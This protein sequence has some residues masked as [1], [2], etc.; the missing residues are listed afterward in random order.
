MKLEKYRV[1]E[2]YMRRHM[3]DSAH[4]TGHIQRVLGMAMLLARK[5]EAVDNDVLIAS[6]LLHDVGRE[7]QFRTGESHAIISA[8]MARAF[9]SEQGEEEA[10]IDH[11]CACI[12]THSFRRNDPPA[13]IAARLLYDADKLD[14]VGAIGMA[15]TFLY[16][17]RVSD[18]IYSVG[19]NGEVLSGEEK[20]PSFY[21]E[22]RH[23]LQNMGGRFLTA[24]AKKRAAYRSE[25]ARAFVD[26]LYAEAAAG[27]S[28]PGWRVLP[29][30][31]TARQRRIY[32]IALLMAGGCGLSAYEELAEAVMRGNAAEAQGQA[33]A[34]I[35]DAERLD[36]EGALGIAQRFIELGSQGKNM[37]LIFE[38]R[39]P[40]EYRTGS[41]EEMAKAR[42]AAAQAYLRDLRA[43]MDDGME[44]GMRLLAGLLL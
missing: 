19:E 12:R 5:E 16:Q 27:E 4:D 22:Y 32:N 24:E 18:P 34:L 2:E 37:N 44:E 25:S 11:V 20:A 43:E 3:L 30:E 35:M 31:A 13:T 8:R 7:E 36:D 39:T 33:A 10:F 6:A 38:E 17:G 28:G 15:R 14:V 29:K 23:K 40:G 42:W 41:A 1:Y 21:S 26:A 9:L